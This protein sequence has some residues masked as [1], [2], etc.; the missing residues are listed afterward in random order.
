MLIVDALLGEAP[1][2]SEEVEERRHNSFTYFLKDV[3]QDG[4]YMKQDVP[5][6]AHEYLHV[7]GKGV[8][9]NQKFVQDSYVTRRDFHPADPNRIEGYMRLM[10]V[11]SNRVGRLSVKDGKLCLQS[12]TQRE[13]G[14]LPTPAPPKESVKHE[15]D[16]S[17]AKLPKPTRL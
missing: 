11:A 9:V 16:E 1:G 7:W 6:I 12:A 10:V 14:M 4:V 17:P 13:R 3:K 5:S 8:K 15:I 2:L